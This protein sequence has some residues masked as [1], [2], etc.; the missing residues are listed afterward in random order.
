MTG[1]LDRAA[2]IERFA[3][4]SPRNL[5]EGAVPVMADVAEG[6]YGLAVMLALGDDGWSEVMARA[7]EI[8]AT[9]EALTE[10][11]T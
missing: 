8:V 4:C 2:L 7:A 10:E 6:W 5:M 1:D 11:T 9:R 3:N